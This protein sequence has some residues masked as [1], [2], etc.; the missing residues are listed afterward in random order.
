MFVSLHWMH[1][2][3]DQHLE[4]PPSSLPMSCFKSIFPSSALLLKKKRKKEK[5]VKSPQD[6][7]YCDCGFSAAPIITA[8][9]L[10]GVS[11][12]CLF[13]RHWRWVVTPC[14]CSSYLGPFSVNRSVVLLSQTFH[15]LHSSAEENKTGNIWPHLACCLIAFWI[16][17][18]LVRWVLL[19]WR[20]TTWK[21]ISGLD[22]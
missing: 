11:I 8:N 1:L 5:K 19:W 14:S 4:A 7:V 20:A 16:L 10:T 15:S 17:G 13:V 12:I 3:W 2:M 6:V 18:H 21:Q 22:K 9:N